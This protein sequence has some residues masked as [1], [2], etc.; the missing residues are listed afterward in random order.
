MS[1]D[2]GIWSETGTTD[3][4]VRVGY[5]E[6]IEIGIRRTQQERALTVTRGD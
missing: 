3:D 1:A 4:S 5:M 2:F 6:T